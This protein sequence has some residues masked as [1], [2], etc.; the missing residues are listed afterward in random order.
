MNELIE[1]TDAFKIFSYYPEILMI[2][3]YDDFTDKYAVMIIERLKNNKEGKTIYTFKEDSFRS[4]EHAIFA[5]TRSIYIAM[6]A[7]RTMMN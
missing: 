7:V 2:P 3:L 5:A 4:E 1:I 6:K